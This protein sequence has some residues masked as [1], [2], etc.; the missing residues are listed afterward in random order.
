[1]KPP[2]S[3]RPWIIGTPHQWLAVAVACLIVYGQVLGFGWLNYDDDV[4][5]ATNPGLHPVTLRSIAHFWTEPYQGLFIPMSYMLYAGE[6]LLSRALSP[7][8]PAAAWLFHGTSVLLHIACVLL[9]GRVLTQRVGGGWPALAGTLLFALHPLQV[10]SVAWISEQRGLLA[11]ALS[12]GSLCLTA[13][14]SRPETPR[15]GMAR[16]GAAILLFVLAILAKPSATVLPLMIAILDG[17]GSWRQTIAA[18]GRLWPWFAVAAVFAVVTKTQQPS[19]WSW[20]G[21]AVPLALRPLVAGDAICFYVEKFLVPLGLCVDYGRI[22][23]AVLANAWLCGRAVLM[24]AVIASLC[25]VPQ[26]RQARVPAG[27]TIAALLPVLGLVPFTFQGFSTVADRYT[28]LPMIGPAIA[29]AIAVQ[30]ALTHGSK[31]VYGIIAAWLLTLTGPT[32]YQLPVWH[33][34]AALHAQTVRVN[35]R[36][37]C[38]HLGLGAALLDEGRLGEAAESL[39]AAVAANPAY[40][41]AQYQLASTLHKLGAR[42]EAEEHYRSTIR[43]RP[44]Y[45][46][47][48]NDL[49]I[50]LAEQGRVDEAIVHFREA[51]TLRPDL[52]AHRKNLERAESLREQGMLPHPDA[53]P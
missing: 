25:V 32:L 1:V 20:E 41:K 15:Q 14:P 45:S 29:V 31:A 27:L 46:Y 34:S 37:A 39:R 48:H 53:A 11:T 4:H 26:V 38:G 2:E 23:E 36:S 9:V 47:A 30:W 21:A 33:D 49:G 17:A 43:L 13:R 51:V 24:L 7:E 3:L 16:I 28:Y 12:L 8:D 52:P 19:E 22:P 40:V 44:Q 5:V 6:M 10:E 18:A 42:A 50:L 35:P